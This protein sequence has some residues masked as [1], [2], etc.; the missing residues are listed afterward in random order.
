MNM[1][2]CKLCLWVCYGD[3]FLLLLHWVKILPMHP[4]GICCSLFK[5][6]SQKGFCESVCVICRILCVRVRVSRWRREGAVCSREPESGVK[7][8][9]RKWRIPLKNCHSP[10]V[11]L[12]GNLNTYTHTKAEP[13]VVV[14]MMKTMVHR[15]WDTGWKPLNLGNQAREW[16]QRGGG[17]R[18][19]SR[20]IRKGRWRDMWTE[21]GGRKN[22]NKD[23]SN[24]AAQ[25]KLNV[26]S[27]CLNTSLICLPRSYISALSR[28]R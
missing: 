17:G 8:M 19:T 3:G 18:K 16:G 26:W 4:H 20:A 24:R 1:N 21:K 2:E 23:K 15:I 12:N 7:E 14:T 28:I 25:E 6:C 11:V 13:V 10:F 22:I 9:G 5:V 27:L